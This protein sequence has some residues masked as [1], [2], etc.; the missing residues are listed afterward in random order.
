LNGVLEEEDVYIEQLLG[1]K[2][3]KTFYGQIKFGV[4]VVVVG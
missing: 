2:G 3:K 1:Y 4:V